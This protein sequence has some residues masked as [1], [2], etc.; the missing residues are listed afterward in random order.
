MLKKYFKEILQAKEQ[1][2][3]DTKYDTKLVNI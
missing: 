1:L 3:E 2:F